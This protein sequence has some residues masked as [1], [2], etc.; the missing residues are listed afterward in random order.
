LRKETESEE[1]IDRC[2]GRSA[3]PNGE[4]TEMNTMRKTIAIAAFSTG[5]PLAAAFAL[6][7]PVAHADVTVCEQGLSAIG[8]TTCSFAFAVKNAYLQQLGPTGTGN[9]YNVYSPVTGQ[10][11][12]LYCSRVGNSTLCTGGNGAEVNLF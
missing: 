7:I 12:N 11:Y 4:V 3:R 9:L 6:S 5:M 10:S 1:I 2:G 8:P